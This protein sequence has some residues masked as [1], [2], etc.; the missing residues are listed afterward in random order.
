MGKTYPCLLTHCPLQVTF[1]FQRQWK[2]ILIVVVQDGLLRHDDKLELLREPAS[3]V[4]L[5]HRPERRLPSLPRSRPRSLASSAT[6]RYV[7]TADADGHGAGGGWGDGDDTRVGETAHQGR[8]EAQ[9]GDGHLLPPPVDSAA[10]HCHL[11]PN[12]PST[13]SRRQALA[14]L[15]ADDDKFDGNDDDRQQTVSQLQHK[16]CSC[17]PL[18]WWIL[19]TPL[20]FSGFPFSVVIC[21][22]LFFKCIFFTFVIEFV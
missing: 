21:C 10:Q 20:S 18:L 13:N 2:L 16:L 5:Q 11:C 9:L 1:Q 19:S 17:L 22:L 3:L 7:E 4:D 8:Q 6:A 12:Q 14:F 15:A